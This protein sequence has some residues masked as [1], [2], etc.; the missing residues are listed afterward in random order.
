M[1]WAS[2]AAQL[3]TGFLGAPPT[4]YDKTFAKQLGV[5]TQDVNDF[6][7]WDRNVELM[8]SIPHTCSDKELLIHCMAA[9]KIIDKYREAANP[10]V[11][12]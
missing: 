8:T 10:V 11:E 7:G 1:G 2:F 4:L 3:L 6:L 9:K 12:L 5:T